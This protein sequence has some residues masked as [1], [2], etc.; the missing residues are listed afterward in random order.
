MPLLYKISSHLGQSIQVTS[1]L[2]IKFIVNSVI[3][4]AGPAN[5]PSSQKIVHHYPRH[6]VI[7]QVDFRERFLFLNSFV[8]RI[9]SLVDSLVVIARLRS[10]D[11]NLLTNLYFQCIRKNYKPLEVL[12]NSATSNFSECL[13][14]ILF[15]LKLNSSFNSQS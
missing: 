8:Q 13:T 12:F 1:C 4:V 15:F 2:Y 10:T 9:A 6:S 11:L 7:S 14:I 3:R 5:K